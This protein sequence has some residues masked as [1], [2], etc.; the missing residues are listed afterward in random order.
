[1]QVHTAEKVA[2]GIYQVAS[3]QQPVASEQG[4][5][6]DLDYI[7]TQSVRLSKKPKIP[8]IIFDPRLIQAALLLRYFSVLY[9]F[10]K[11]LLWAKK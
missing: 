7:A 8:I 11:G 6:A 5:P 10:R 4:S 2:G 3:G 9:K 1:M